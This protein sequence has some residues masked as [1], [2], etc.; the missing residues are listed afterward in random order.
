MPI[1]AFVELPV[2]GIGVRK[3]EFNSR[4]IDWPVVFE[5]S[6]IPVDDMVTPLNLNA[7]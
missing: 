6:A 4:A 2:L 7:E 5:C 3:G 1:S